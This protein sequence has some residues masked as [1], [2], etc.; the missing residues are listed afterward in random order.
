MEFLYRGINEKLYKKLNGKIQPKPQKY[1]HEFQSCACC[2]D[3]HAVCGSGIVTGES[4]AN[5]V[6]FHQW[7]QEG[8]PTSGVSTSPIKERAKFYA[9]KN[10]EYSKGYIY[11]LSVNLL[12]KNGVSIYKVGDYTAFP[13]VPEDDE[14]IIVAKN[15]KEIPSIG[16]VAIE[17]IENDCLK[18]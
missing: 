14:H 10:G 3:P 16:I 7:N 9:L 17:F 1:G 8:Y 12:E 11:K 2:G 6:I 15:F 13:A 5:E 4:I 18:W